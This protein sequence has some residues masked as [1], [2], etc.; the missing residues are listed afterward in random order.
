MCSQQALSENTSFPVGGESLDQTGGSGSVLSLSPLRTR[1]RMN[2]NRQLDLRDCLG[3][4]GKQLAKSIVELAGVRD[5]RSKPLWS[6][7]QF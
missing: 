6:G 5:P 1:C 4:P 7:V 3:R 2:L